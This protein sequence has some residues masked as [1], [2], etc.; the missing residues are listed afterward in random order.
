M[1][2]DDFKEAYVAAYLAA[3]AAQ[4]LPRVVPPQIVELAYDL[5]EEAYNLILDRMLRLKKQR[6]GKD[7]Q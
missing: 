5:A 2:G 3:K 4:Q 6:G 7:V 1:T